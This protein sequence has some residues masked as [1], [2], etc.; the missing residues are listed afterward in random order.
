MEVLE[1][2]NGICPQH[3]AKLSVNGEARCLKCESKAENAL[4]NQPVV[5]VEDPGH[6]AMMGFIAP[7]ASA[8]PVVKQSLT[9]V[10]TSPIVV[11]G[12]LQAIRDAIYK[13]PM[14]KS[15]KQF[16]RFQKIQ[17]LIDQALSEEE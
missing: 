14:P 15:M 13:L 1:F 4:K 10:K 16:K 8:A 17:Q 9:V 3:G 11:L 12:S 2:P 5:T 7:D 6:E